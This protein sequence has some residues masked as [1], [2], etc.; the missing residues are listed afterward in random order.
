MKRTFFFTL[1]FLFPVLRCY[2]VQTPKSIVGYMI[3]SEKMTSEDSAAVR[4]MQN[5][6]SFTPQIINL[7]ERVRQQSAVDILWVHLPDSSSYQAFIKDRRVLEFLKSFHAS[8][9]KMF[10]TDYAAMLPHQL[11][12]ET[13]KPEVRIDSI[14]ND[15]LFDEKGFQSFRGHPIFR[16]LFG[17]TFV[18]DANVDQVLPFI[19]FFG[20]NFPEKGKVVA[21]DKSYVFVHGERKVVVEYCNAQGKIL[22]VGSLIYFSRENN[23]KRNLEKFIEN[24]LVYLVGKQTTDA[25]TYWMKFENIPKR[26]DVHSEPI[27]AL[28]KNPSINFP[29]SEL[30]LTRDAPHNDFYDVAGRRALIMGRENGGIEEMWVHPFRVLR[31]YEVGLVAGD[32]VSWLSKLPVKI[33][34][35]PE[36][37][38]RIYST[39]SGQLKE[40]IFPSLLK[41]GGVVHYE[42]NSAKPIQLLLRFRCDLR[43]M[44]PYDYNALGDIHYAYDAGL[45]ALHVKDTSGSF[46]SLIGGDIPPA[47]QLA[48]R[49]GAINWTSGGLVGTPTEL[50]QVYSASI[51]DLSSENKQ[52]LN[53]AVVGTNEGEQ[54]AIREYR[55]LLLDPRTEYAE[56]VNHYQNLLDTKLTIESPDREFNTLFKWTLVGTDR[57]WVNVPSLGTALVAGYSTT[58]RGWDG[59]Q[60]INGRPGY[61]WYFGRDSEWSGFAIDDYGDFELVKEQLEFL[62]RHQDFYG[63]IFHEISTSGVVHFD[64][65]DATP[66]YLILAAHYLRASGDMAFIQKSWP[67]LQKAMEFL[68]ST[69]TDGDL[70]IENTNVGHGWVEGGK[71]FGAHTETY[72]AALWAQSLKDMAFIAA[73]LNK[74]GLSEKY[75][76][77]ATLVQ[78]ILNRDFW[79]D[80]TQFF[81]YGKMKDG[82]YNA[83][84]TVLP[85]VA[86][87]YNLL[88]DEKVTTMLEEYAGNGFS[89]D[90]GVRILSAD[91]P[92]FNPSGY[93]YGSVWPL[94]TGWTAL[95]EYEYGNSNQGF[96]HITNNLYIKNHWALGYVEE[97]M[98]GAEY[99]PSGVCPHQCWSETNILHPAI[100]GMIGWEPN[101][102]ENSADLKPRLPLQWDSVT[103]RN[104][105]VGTSVLQYSLARGIN[106]T[107]HSFT[108][109][110]GPGVAVNFAP[111]IPAGMEIK[112]ILLDGRPVEVNRKTVRGLLAVPTSFVVKKRSEVIFE[113][114]KGIGMVP[115]TPKPAPGDSSMGWR[116]ITASLEGNKYAVVVQGKSGTDAAFVLKFFDQTID[117]VDNAE[118][119]AGPKGGSA[120]LRVMF[121]RSSDKY[122]QK[123]M[124]VHLR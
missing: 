109:L 49:F 37:F 124:V 24:S 51:F 104:L 34:I 112:K 61:A 121:D 77:D 29:A 117:R 97:V 70:L 113:H 16:G 56:L 23:L 91:S 14:Q 103:V 42:A 118:I 10:F 67:H 79:N 9:G 12:I 64:A 26:F 31:D 4:W 2:G 6:E 102:L 5:H 71:L 46:Y 30:L 53:V 84:R 122:V 115:I 7:N 13:A 110:Q 114:S 106:R 3:V 28:P 123:K 44:W 25:T 95:G 107:T 88:D 119:E 33:E 47:Q 43:W 45:Q 93:H 92:L 58:A 15:W 89:S 39:A 87:Y 54:S 85:A 38:T 98:N 80:S 81:N 20:N 75:A 105:H 69:D 18:W 96:M 120:T 63:K 27:R 1:L 66:L 116:I 32:T 57:F 65:S 40:I 55:S 72:L 62:Q 35:R 8:G 83:E 111:E 59:A 22:A 90:W 36:S 74:K 68:Y 11:G 101:A 99:R 52:C 78:K 100:R 48:G 41:A 19:G 76:S 60:K 82:S 21:V 86:M 50:N 73:R 94:F 108:L 17:G